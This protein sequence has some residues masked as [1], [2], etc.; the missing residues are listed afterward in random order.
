MVRTMRIKSAK[1]KDGIE[2]DL[3]SV[4]NEV[5]G[6]I[7]DFLFSLGVDEG[8]S[9]FV[10]SYSTHAQ[11]QTTIDFLQ[12]LRDSFPSSKKR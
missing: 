5:S 7:Y 4:S 10:R 12:I 6:K 2:V 11:R 3:L 9:H 1:E 8:L